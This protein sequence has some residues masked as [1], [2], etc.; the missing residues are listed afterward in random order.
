MQKY[1]VGCTKIK[2]YTIFFIIFAFRLYKKLFSGFPQYI[3]HFWS[4]AYKLTLNKRILYTEE[5]PKIVFCIAEKQK[6]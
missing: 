2:I 5:N 3:K 6:L 1:C 4:V